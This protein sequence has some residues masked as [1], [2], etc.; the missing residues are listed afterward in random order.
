[1]LNVNSMSR[2]QPGSSRICHAAGD[3]YNTKYSLVVSTHVTLNSHVK[4]NR[5]AYIYTQSCLALQQV[6]KW[7]SK[8]IYSLNNKMHVACTRFHTAPKWRLPYC[9]HAITTFLNTFFNNVTVEFK[10]IKVRGILLKKCCDR[11]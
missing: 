6:L 10:K 7:F 4:F 3:K 1:M 2:Y 8:S 5:F 9:M 11:W